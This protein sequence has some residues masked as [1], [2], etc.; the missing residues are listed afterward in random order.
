MYRVSKKEER[1]FQQLQNYRV[2]KSQNN[3][4]DDIPKKFKMPKPGR[5]GRRR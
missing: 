4:K 1:T 3:T 2:R 5:T